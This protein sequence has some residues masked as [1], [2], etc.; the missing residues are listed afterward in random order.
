MYMHVH[1]HVA[2]WGSADLQWCPC[3]QHPMG[4][5]V[6]LVQHLRQLAVMV[7]HPM[8]LVDDHVLPVNLDMIDMPAC[9]T[10]YHPFQERVFLKVLMFT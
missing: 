7:L 2:G 5:V 3:E 4:G 6:V 10:V 1:A 9:T 8:P